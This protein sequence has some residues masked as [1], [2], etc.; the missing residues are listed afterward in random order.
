MNVGPNLVSV[1][2]LGGLVPVAVYALALEGIAA[3]A[4]LNVVI[5]F[6]CLYYIFSGGGDQ[7]VPVGQ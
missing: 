5:I 6:G 3:V 2:L 1:L 4:L 7:L